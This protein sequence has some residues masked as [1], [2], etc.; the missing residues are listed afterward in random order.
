[1]IINKIASVRILVEP[2]AF[3]LVVLWNCQFITVKSLS[4]D[5]T[6]F[7]ICSLL[8]FFEL[9]VTEKI[10]VSFSNLCVVIPFNASSALP[11][12]SGHPSHRNPSRKTIPSTSKVAVSIVSSVFKQ[13]TD[14]NKN[15]MSQ[16]G[17]I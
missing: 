14:N 4:A 13:P 1:M 16:R 9:K 6:A 11:I 2:E 12:L 3:H 7:M 5:S 10:C 17:F 15:N 8:I